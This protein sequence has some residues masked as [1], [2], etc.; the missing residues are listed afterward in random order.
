MKIKK[1]NI[2]ECLPANNAGEVFEPLIETEGLKIE[3]IVSQGHT[4]PEGTWYDQL[5]NEWVMLLQGEA[6]IEFENNEEVSLVKGD[7]VLLPAH[8]RHRVSWT[9]PTQPSIWL[10]IHYT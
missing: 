6:K 7:S 4:T 5:Q 9:H 3:R 1:Q 2:F 8:T 10:A